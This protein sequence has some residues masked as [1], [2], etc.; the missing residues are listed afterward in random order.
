MRIISKERDYYDCVQKFAADDP[1]V[2]LRISRRENITPDD[3]LRDLLIS[4]WKTYLD[5]YTFCN[6]KYK[7]N[8]GLVGFC[9]KV[10]PALHVSYSVG[11]KDY[12][13]HIYDI[14]HMDKF[15]D[16]LHDKKATEAYTKTASGRFNKKTTRD[17]I[18]RFFDKWYGSD[19]FEKLFWEFKSP[20]FTLS[21]TFEHKF[22]I[23]SYSNTIT[24]DMSFKVNGSLKN[25][26]FQKVFDPY[27]AAQEIEMY[28]F[29]VLGCTEKD[30][31]QISD[32][33]MRNQK[34]F[35][36]MSFKKSPT[37]RLKK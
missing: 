19:K 27:L 35:D 17:N 9:G 26:G 22:N 16:A 25:Y 28:Y 7:M 13:Q 3:S 18:L 29:G 15:I 6:Y 31:V 24:G 4:F 5:G 30:T 20:V 32:L 23:N 8:L 36:N 10:Y 33:D 37:K 1:N 34:G 2:Y 12:T 11:V 14:E 21:N